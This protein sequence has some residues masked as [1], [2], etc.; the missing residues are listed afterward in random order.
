M[1]CPGTIV[2][3]AKQS[4]LSF[5][6]ISR[7][8]VSFEPFGSCCFWLFHIFF[9]FFCFHRF[10]SKGFFRLLICVFPLIWAVS[11]VACGY[12]WDADD[13]TSCPVLE[14]WDVVIECE[15]FVIQYIQ[16]LFL[17]KWI[18]AIKTIYCVFRCQD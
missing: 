15:V 1:N 9:H 8:C 18:H 11:C 4:M 14:I 2:L 13:V 5:L 17:P 6:L 3:I 16:C 10:I 12:C 7:Y